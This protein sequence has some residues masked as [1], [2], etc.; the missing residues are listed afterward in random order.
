MRSTEP[1]LT[2]RKRGRRTPVSFDARGIAG[3]VQRDSSET[4]PVDDTRIRGPPHAEPIT[5][6]VREFMRLS[7]LSHPTV[8]RMLGRGD[9]DT[10]KIGTKRLIL[11]ASYRALIARQQAA[12]ERG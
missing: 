2:V 10:V 3:E 5:V 9:L 1:R 8:Y 12:E 7:G 4:Q 11:L 6:G